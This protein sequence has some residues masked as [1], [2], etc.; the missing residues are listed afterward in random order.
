MQ[1]VN[2]LTPS[3]LNWLDVCD[4]LRCVVIRFLVLRRCCFLR[5]G[6]IWCSSLCVRGALQVKYW[7]AASPGPISD[8]FSVCC[9]IVRCAAGVSCGAK[10]GYP[11]LC[12]PRELD[13]VARKR[14]DF[15]VLCRT[16]PRSA[17]KCFI[18][19]L[20]PESV[21]RVQVRSVYLCEVEAWSFNHL[22]TY[23]TS[24]LVCAERSKDLN[25][26]WCCTEVISAM[27]AVWNLE[28]ACVAVCSLL[29]RQHGSHACQSR[30][31]AFLLDDF[32]STSRSDEVMRNNLCGGIALGTSTCCCA[33]CVLTPFRCFPSMA[34]V[35]VL[36]AVVWRSACDWASVRGA[37]YLWSAIDWPSSSVLVVF[38][39]LRVILG[40]SRSL[41]VFSVLCIC[42]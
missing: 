23:L 35:F 13:S 28:F 27:G 17:S 41:Q 29:V 25:V 38:S 36:L 14:T 8:V 10:I 34:V 26:V 4:S 15:E 32:V 9:V 16:P 1:P 22:V 30:A 11:V 31:E 19:G 7:K 18:S 2:L 5:P 20:A 42:F 21:S 6:C 24:C 33:L 37:C 3:E 12:D 40:L 39:D